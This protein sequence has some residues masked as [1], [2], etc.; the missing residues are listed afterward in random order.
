MKPKIHAFSGETGAGKTTLSKRLA[1]KLAAF[2][3]SHDELL[4]IAYDPEQLAKEHSKCCERANDLAWKM[5]EKITS[6]GIDVVLEGWGSRA[7]RDLI[8]VKAEEL[9]LDVEFYYVSCPQDERLRRIRKRNQQPAAD[10][11]Y[12]SNEDFF[13]MKEVDEGFGEGESFT[14]IKNGGHNQSLLSTPGASPLPR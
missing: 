4:S 13:R 12:I 14:E 1:K 3:I 7:L 8:R 11:P 6:L 9:N 10:A 2:R 5:V